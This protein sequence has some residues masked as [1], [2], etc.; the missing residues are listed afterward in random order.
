MRS[1]AVSMVMFVLQPKVKVV[2]QKSGMT[3]MVPAEA[4][5]LMYMQWPV[6]GSATRKQWRIHFQIS[7]LCIQCTKLAGSG[8]CNTYIPL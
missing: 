3:D 6:A 7:K 1:A 5:P 2:A 8:T 4:T